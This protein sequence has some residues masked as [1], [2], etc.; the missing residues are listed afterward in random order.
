MDKDKGYTADQLYKLLKKA[1]LS[2]DRKKRTERRIQ[3]AD[4][5]GDQNL[6]DVIGFSL[7]AKRG[8]DYAGLST[9]ENKTGEVR[10]FIGSHTQI[11]GPPGVGKSLLIMKWL[12]D[13]SNDGNHEDNTVIWPD[14]E[15]DASR[16]LPSLIE[17]GKLLVFPSDLIKKNLLENIETSRQWLGMF[18]KTPTEYWYIGDAGY[19]LITNVGRHLTQPEI[20]T[21]MG[22]HATLGEVCENIDNDK[23]KGNE[24]VKDYRAV[25][26]FR[27]N[28]LNDAVGKIFHNRRGYDPKH[29]RGRVIVYDYSQLGPA[30]QLFMM[31]WEMMDAYFKAQY[32]VY[33]KTLLIA[34][35]I[36]RMYKSAMMRPAPLFEPTLLD[37]CRSARKRGLTC[38]FTDHSLKNSPDDIS[39]TS[40]TKV[41]FRLTQADDKTLAERAICLDPDLTSELSKL[42]NRYCI[43]FIGGQM[44]APKLYKTPDVEFTE[45]PND[46]VREMMLPYI[47]KIPFVPVI[48]TERPSGKPIIS[49]FVLRNRDKIG[50]YLGTLINNPMK[51]IPVFTKPLRFTV[52]DNFVL[53]VAEVNFTSYPLTH[54]FGRRGHGGEQY[55][56][57]MPAGA[58]FIGERYN[59]VKL[60]GGKNKS[61]QAKIAVNHIY[62]HRLKAG[63]KV[64][65]E[66][67]GADVV[68]WVE[69]S[70]FAYEYET[71]VYPHIITNCMRNFKAL[72]ADGIYIVMDT[73]TQL[74]E[75]K[76]LL[77]A[78]LSK[79]DFDRVGY[80]KT[81]KFM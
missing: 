35:E 27:M 77:K 40:D 21:K 42:R 72:G 50:M 51:H 8:S 48:E 7:K 64:K 26:S 41:Y 81:E 39:D 62:N 80:A 32:G 11:A 73:K 52:D 38:I 74:S 15:G 23:I 44:D 37:V 13:L 3:W 56:E 69:D 79:E 34:E 67:K 78:H 43:N 60:P 14:L 54:A 68:E 66:F 30:S 16:I 10:F 25:T 53:K 49:E 55:V 28:F 70:I 6:F 22:G 9:L 46:V 58:A 57:I 2:E 12:K 63:S 65:M 36:H 5:I 20:V 71:E 4:M 45:Y 75:A 47:K 76:K 33:G 1:D 59:K 61:L 31:G 17:P 19:V 29:L 18:G 24:P